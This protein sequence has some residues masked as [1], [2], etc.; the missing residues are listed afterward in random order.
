[1]RRKT[2]LDA[3]RPL[4]LK[5]GF[6]ATT[7]PQIAA[8]AELA[9]GTLYLYY[10]SKI[11]IYAEL[12]HEG[13]DVLIGRLQEAVKGKAAA[14]AQATALVEAFLDFAKESPE[15]F[16]TLFFLLQREGR[17]AAQALAP[18]QLAALHQREDV[19]KA[20]AAS[21]LHH[22]P[23]E[24]RAATVEAVWTMLAGLAFFMRTDPSFSTVGKEAKRVLI[25]GLF[26]E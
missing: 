13:Y 21:I 26:T 3:A 11:A 10:P 9:P 4:F 20:L 23:T 2:I 17:W 15:Y 7:M 6:A 8:A 14:R 5:N 16:D 25:A 22:L 24:R 1:A 19:C 12:L 18:E